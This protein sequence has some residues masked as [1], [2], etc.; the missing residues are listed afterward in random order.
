MKGEAMA[1]N[2]D[3]VG[4]LK[5]RCEASSQAAVA[6]ECGVSETYISLVLSGR[7][8]IGP[9]LAR[10]FGYRRGWVTLQANSEGA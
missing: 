1:T 2:A 9:K 7:Q 10:I 8:K 4:M 6:R 5:A 3:L